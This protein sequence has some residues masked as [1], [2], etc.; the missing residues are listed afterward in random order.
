MCADND[1]QAADTWNIFLKV[2]TGITKFSDRRKASKI[3]F[4]VHL[5]HLLLNLMCS[6]G[7]FQS[8]V[9]SFFTSE[10]PEFLLKMEIALFVFKPHTGPKVTKA[11]SVSGLCPLLL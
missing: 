6:S 4:T 10:T 2:A 3:A 1:S 9:P 8:L 5:S 7:N 11:N